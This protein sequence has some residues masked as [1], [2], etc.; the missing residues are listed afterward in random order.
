M[1][2][3]KYILGLLVITVVVPN[4]FTS[5]YI[6]RAACTPVR[7]VV[8]TPDPSTVKAGANYNARI[9]AEGDTT[10]LVWTKVRGDDWL[11]V[12]AADDDTP[13]GQVYGSVPADYKPEVYSFVAE[14]SSCGGQPSRQKLTFTVEAANPQSPPPT[15]PTTPTTPTDPNIVKV[16]DNP[17]NYSTLLEL[18]LAVMR[19][20]L[21][22][23]GMISTVAIVYGGITIV[24]SS[25]NPSAVERGKSILTWSVAGFALSLLAFSIVN[26]IRSFFK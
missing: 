18:F 5:K 7:I 25:G 15:A 6:A 13:D 12:R 1:L 23:V 22:V 16:F 4:F 11:Q 14:A 2:K 17:L 8:D 20:M 3:I 21:L 19:I 10:N 26:I 24:I 9:K